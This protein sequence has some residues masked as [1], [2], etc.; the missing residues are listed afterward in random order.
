M[1]IIL[2][3]DVGKLGSLGDEL[4]VKPGFARNYL[5]PQ[6]KAVLITRANMKR[7]NHRRI[8]LA[9]QREDA[10]ATSKTMAKK[11]EEAELIF[12]RKSGGSGKL[13]GSV[14]QKH[15]AKLS[16]NTELRRTVKIFNFPVRSKRLATTSSM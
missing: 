6:G 13:F 3:Q 9:K 4:K 10:I 15:I 8:S 14:T 12:H 16:T 7:L 11:L 1:K 2:T 5:I